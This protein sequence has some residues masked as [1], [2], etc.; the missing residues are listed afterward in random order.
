M[1]RLVACFIRIIELLFNIGTGK[2]YILMNSLVVSVFWKCS[3]FCSVLILN[4]I[5]DYVYEIEVAV[6]YQ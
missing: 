2:Y 1:N 6:S 3:C 5:E 4:V